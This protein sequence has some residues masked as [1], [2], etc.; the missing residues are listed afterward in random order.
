M[1]SFESFD[2]L[3]RSQE[4]GE[5]WHALR[6]FMQRAWFKRRWIVQE[7]AFAKDAEVYCGPDKVSWSEL[8]SAMS[9]FATK[10]DDLRHMFQK[11]EKFGYNP[12]YLGEIDAYGA[13]NLVDT[14]DFMFRKTEDGD[15]IM[16]QLLSLE[17]VLTNLTAFD[18][19]RPHD[20]VYAVMRLSND[21]RPVSRTSMAQ[22]LGPHSELRTI[23]VTNQAP[24]GQRNENDIPIIDSNGNK[25]VDISISEEQSRGRSRERDTFLSNHLAAPERA[26]SRARS[27][28]GAKEDAEKEYR[29]QP[30][31]FIVN[32]QR[33]MF[34]L[35]SEI[36]NFVVQRSNS[37][38]MICKPW[39]PNLEEFSSKEARLHEDDL[40]TMPSWIQSLDKGPY[41]LN[42]NPGSI[43]YSRVA[44]DPPGYWRYACKWAFTQ[45][46]AHGGNLDTGALLR[47]ISGTVSTP[48]VPFLHRLR[49]V[50][51]NRQLIRTT[52]PDP[53]SL[54]LLGLAPADASPGD[55]IC[56]LLGCSVPV[57]LRPK[58]RKAGGEPQLRAKAPKRRQWYK[59]D[60]ASRAQTRSRTMSAE[61]P[62][63]MESGSPRSP[64]FGVRD[65]SENPPTSSLEATSLLE[66]Y[67]LI[68]E[69]YIHGMMD[70]EA[71]NQRD[72]HDI[73]LRDFRI[74]CA[75]ECQ[76]NLCEP[77]W[78]IP[79]VSV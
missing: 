75:M 18:A 60:D 52:G 56:I 12:D 7:I 11:S 27:P 44:A 29:T 35:C 34:G 53:G 6:N 23:N 21:A 69:C 16:E 9:L 76:C 30:R 15:I 50:I 70:G 13:K 39:V 74:G 68:G 17:S 61:A 67:S 58:I 57:V 8:S 46:P 42:L 32:Y 26:R 10:G 25:S 62:R 65:P 73:P 33:S 63:R 72:L 59:S 5:K 55:K 14:I 3:C 2:K 54:G 36:I 43:R 64:Q 51:W 48:V 20:Y 71:F 78:Q 19:D 45:R 41:G 40:A 49:A 4:F 38:D 22:D 31:Q 79:N 66:E 37:I 1:L 47:D 28:V 24:N 77:N